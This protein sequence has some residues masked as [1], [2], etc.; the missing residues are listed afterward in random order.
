MRFDCVNLDLISVS[1]YQR[2]VSNHSGGSRSR[3]VANGLLESMEVWLLSS[4]C[5]FDRNKWQVLETSLKQAFK[6]H[7]EK[8]FVAFRLSDIEEVAHDAT[9]WMWKQRVIHQR[10][11]FELNVINVCFDHYPGCQSLMWLWKAALRVSLLLAK[12]RKL[13]RPAI[14]IVIVCWGNTSITITFFHLFYR[15]T[16]DAS[17]WPL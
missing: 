9:A 16:L 5:L 8:L 7:W 13:P 11:L 10:Q 6:V 15:Y 1:I 3:I 4:A 17:V 2:D 14:K 12:T